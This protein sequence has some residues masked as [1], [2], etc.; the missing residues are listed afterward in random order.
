MSPS[1]LEALAVGEA[2]A[3]HAIVEDL[4]LSGLR[5]R[6]QGQN[7]F[8]TG[9]RIRIDLYLREPNRRYILLTVFAK[10][11][12][13]DGG[14]VYAHFGPMALADHRRLKA[15]IDF[16]SAPEGSEKDCYEEIMF[17]E[18]LDGYDTQ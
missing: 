16:T 3:A 2:V 4:S 6:L 9:E 8:L 5:L 17:E 10:V 1:W 7:P 11:A 15:I 13:M 14:A 12:K 18:L